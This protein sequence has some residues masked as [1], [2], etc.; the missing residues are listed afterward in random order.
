[1]KK[2]Y[3]L[4]MELE[5]N[6]CEHITSGDENLEKH[7]NALLRVFLSDPQLISEFYRHLILTDAYNSMAAPDFS[8]KIKDEI[9]RL[10]KRGQAN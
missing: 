3:L 6:I 1:M 2:K 4:V 8:E 10:L 5:A 9:A 7:L